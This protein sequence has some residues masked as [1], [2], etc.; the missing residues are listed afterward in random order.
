MIDMN[1][2][3]EREIDSLG[4]AEF[5]KKTGFLKVTLLTI[6]ETD[7]LKSCIF[8]MSREFS[9]IK[10]ELAGEMAWKIDIFK[11]LYSFIE[12]QKLCINE[13]IIRICEQLLSPDLV[14]EQASI[15][16]AQKG[17]YYRQ[18]WHRDVWQL[19]EKVINNNIF[20]SN[21]FYNSIQVNLALSDDDCFWIVPGTHKRP[22]RPEE[23]DLFLGSKYYTPIN[24]DMPN[25][26][27]IFLNPGEA[28]FYNNY[29]LHRGHNEFGRSRNTFHA[30]Y[31]SKKHPPTWHFYNT[32]FGA[33]DETHA[34]QLPQE[35]YS[36]W[37][38]NQA[39]ARSFPSIDFAR[40]AY[41]LNSSKHLK[42]LSDE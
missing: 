12:F 11:Q 21:F 28:I 13:K 17:N 35:L 27:N 39:V 30:S 6:D 1:F 19:P 37:E 8:E 40:T 9:I 23:E 10:K 34:K 20:T 31:H 5:F 29:S 25:Q 16:Y 32:G 41:G 15:L 3:I 2:K 33:L 4:L 38:K 26:Q 7:R 36:M 14:L 24:T 42:T 22:L 18:G